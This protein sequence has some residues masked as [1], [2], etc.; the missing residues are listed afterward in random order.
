[1]KPALT[2]AD[3][4]QIAARGI[5]REEI[6]RQLALFADPPAKMRLD[7]PC[8]LG[9]G[10]E[11]LD[12]GRH[13]AWTRLAEEAAASGRVTV[14]L[15]ASGAATRMFASLLAWLTEHELPAQEEL[16]RRAAAGDVAAGDLARL[17]RE[18]EAF[19]FHDALREHFA[20]RGDDLDSARRAGR[21]EAILAALLAQEGLRL[22]ELPKALVPFHRV[23]GVARTALEEQFAEA[24]LY[25]RDA[26]GR[27]RVHV[28]IAP[29]FAERCLALAENVELS[30]SHQS[31]ATDTIAAR[32]GGEPFRRA[33]GSLLFRP[34]GHGA[35]L[36]NLAAL[37][38]DLTAIKNIDNILPPSGRALAVRW[39]KLLLGRL[40]EI[41]SEIDRAL[42]GL[43]RG[44]TGA[45]V[46]AQRLLRDVLGVDPPADNAAVAGRL[47]RPLRVCGM[48]RNTG[49]PGGGPFWVSRGG[50]LSRQIVEGSQVDHG[51]PAQE[52]IWASATH[53]NPVDIA[54]ALRDRRGRPYDLAR[55]VDRDA[56][57]IAEKT[58]GGEPLRA[59][60]LPGLWNGAMAGWNTVFVEVP[61][62]T[63]APV[64]TVF[65]LLRPEHRA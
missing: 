22:P 7:R 25:A 57:F 23:E 58:H 24:E 60:E 49:E 9:D 14:F 63:F 62:A 29:D 18:L 3:L 35:L 16:E 51:D 42:D 41:R 4:A 13:E 30:V 11:S 8:T 19:A 36:A 55:Y 56:V 6:E 5:P 27:T 65:D 40:L 45:G 31:P 52:A 33:D 20:R 28:T 2:D 64:K 38:P 17:W 10:I 39:K 43:E 15:P 46:D 1:M 53:F 54:A 26:R 47:D 44:A 34:G 48:V 32:R 37:A 21:R 50:E 61:A 59:L 12:P